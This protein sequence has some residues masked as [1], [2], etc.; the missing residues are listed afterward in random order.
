MDYLQVDCDPPTISYEVLQK[1]PF[2]THKFAVITFEHDYYADPTQSIRDKSRKYLESFGYKLVVSNIAPDQYSS[3]EDWWVHPDL[4][5]SKIIEK[6]E[7]TD[8]RTKKA[9]DYML[10]RV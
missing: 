9:E 7:Q 10:G 3:Y 6:M 4:V 1:I 2:H 5:D 8:G